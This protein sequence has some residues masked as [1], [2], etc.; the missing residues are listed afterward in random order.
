[1]FLC[2]GDCREISIWNVFYWV[3]F[4][5]FY[6]LAGS[7]GLYNRDEWVTIYQYLSHFLLLRVSTNTCSVTLNFGLWACMS[8]AMINSCRALRCLQELAAP[9]R[10]WTLFLMH[11]FLMS[12]WEMLPADVLTSSENQPWYWWQVPNSNCFWSTKCWSSIRS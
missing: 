6:I 1:M 4:T 8:S 10:T 2:I 5:V 9:Y 7:K 11:N 3:K 12:D